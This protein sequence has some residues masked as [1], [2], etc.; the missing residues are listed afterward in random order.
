MD[1]PLLD[2]SLYCKRL[3][4]VNAVLL[5]K[6]VDFGFTVHDLGF[7]LERVFLLRQ[8]V[9]FERLKLHVADFAPIVSLLKSVES[10]LQIRFDIGFEI[11]QLFV[12]RFVAHKG[13]DKSFLKRQRRRFRFGLRLA[14]LGARL[15]DRALVFVA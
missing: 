14:D 10:L 5:E 15:G 6:R 13:V 3:L 7:D 12:C 4:D 1:V 9:F 8:D 2:Y 11:F